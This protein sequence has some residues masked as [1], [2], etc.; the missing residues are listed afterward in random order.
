MHERTQRAIARLMF[1]F[2][3]AVPTSITLM[4]VM[5]TWTPW[6]HARTLRTIEG[7]L[8]RDTGLLIE[9][10]DYERPAPSSIHLY[11]VRALDPE[12]GREIAR[13]REVHWAAIDDEVA[14]LLHQPE[15]KSSELRST[16][17]LIHDRFL[18]RP[19]RTSAAVQIA[20]N[21]LTIHSRT[22]ALTLR[23]VDAWIRPLEDSVEATVQCL[24]AISQSNSPFTITASRIRSG[25]SPSTRWLLDTGGTPLPCSALGEY[26]PPLESLGSDA[27]F[28]GTMRWHT[29][30][31]QWW[32]DLGGSRFEQVSLDR[33]FEKHAHRLSGTASIQLERCRIERNNRKSD[34]AGS[35]RA[36][37][38]LI[39]RSLILSAR[40]HLGFNVR[41]PEGMVNSLGDIPYD[42]I[43]LGFNLNNT[44]LR[45]DGIC[46]TEIG[47]ESYPAGVV[48]C[49]DGY[50]LV[51][52]N[53]AT[54]D[55]L[56][57]LT[58]LAPSHSVLV[59]MS[60][61]T[62]WLADILI[63]PSRPLPRGEPSP[64]RIR[65]AEN[66]RGGPTIGQPNH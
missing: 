37:N 57:V 9:I 62:S 2:C 65:S 35:I 31:G 61:Q 56:K 52:S 53:G 1:V 13:V 20:A 63:P 23:D 59:P 16:W 10:G 6:H 21:D 8:S 42:R 48:L 7:E 33:L 30:A 46:R 3:C 27:M 38:G 5:I 4:C 36:K 18:C 29:Q 54:L 66:W 40:E 24:P 41:L 50:P 44:Q 55:S 43:A 64:P 25:E 11:D 49:L 15:L 51:E 47:Y 60:D 14:I 34:I 45:L 17:K 22:G 26:L 32:I 19:E 39:G 28:S 12:T 58:A